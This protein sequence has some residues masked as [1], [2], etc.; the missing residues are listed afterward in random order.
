MLQAP[1]RDRRGLIPVYNEIF[2]PRMEFKGWI[3]D[4]TRSG[5]RGVTIDEV[6][7]MIVDL[8]KMMPSQFIQF[9]EWDQ[10]R[11]EQGN[12]PTKTIVNMW[13]KNETNMA[14]MIGLPKIVKEEMKKAPYKIRGQ[15]G[16]CKIGNESPTK[17]P[18]AKAHALFL[19]R[20][21]S[22]GRR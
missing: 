16:H 13:F 14:T 5:L 10:S 15:E 17:K 4:Y 9:F 21:E 12:W 7:V 18:L 2:M 8:E 20:T 11:K 22:N 6:M 1:L 3:T 19:Q